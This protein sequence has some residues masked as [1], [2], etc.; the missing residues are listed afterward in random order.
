MKSGSIY[1]R[2]TSHFFAWDIV[3]LFFQAKNY[4]SIMAI[5]IIQKMITETKCYLILGSYSSVKRSGGASL[6]TVKPM[7]KAD[8][9]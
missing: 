7:R 3:Q 2:L 1:Q 4:I 8:F 9:I 6:S 5:Q